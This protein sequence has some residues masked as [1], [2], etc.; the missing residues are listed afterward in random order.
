MNPVL[1]ALVKNINIVVENKA[2]TEIK[3]I[4]LSSLKK[5]DLFHTQNYYYERISQSYEN[6]K[7]ISKI[8]AI[9]TMLNYLENIIPPEYKEN[10]Y[11]NISNLNLK[12]AKKLNQVSARY[13]AY[14]N[15]IEINPNTL[16]NLRKN[17]NNNVTIESCFGLMHELTHASSTKRTE[18]GFYC[19]FTKHPTDNENDKNDGLTEGM[20]ELI[21]INLFQT[22]K[23]YLSPYYMELCFINQLMILVGKE[24]M[25]SSYFGNQGLNGILL[26]LNKLIDDKELSFKLFRMI[27]LNFYGRKYNQIQ[28]FATE[29]QSILF[30]YFKEKLNKTNSKEEKEKLFYNFKNSLIKQDLLYKIKKN[31]NNYIGLFEYE[32]KLNEFI[33][34]EKTRHF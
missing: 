20:T 4:K 14:N 11:K 32:E 22:N 19:G 2:L 10:F 6:N 15:V 17:I 18:E 26:K 21:T 9:Y 33:K 31:P 24:T 34:E 5:E 27:E 30:D 25:I 13:D 16:K 7:K 1:V 12:S 3:E 29:A 28:K 23:K 8:P